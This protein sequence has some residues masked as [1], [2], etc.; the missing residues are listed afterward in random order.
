MYKAVE[1]SVYTCDAPN[2]TF[3][4]GHVAVRFE[5]TIQADA[6]FDLLNKERRDTDFRS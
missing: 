6:A 1:D 5:N 3:H 4:V 2:Q